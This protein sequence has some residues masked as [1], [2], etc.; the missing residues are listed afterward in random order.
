M[1][2]VDEMVPVSIL[3]LED[4]AFPRVSSGLVILFCHVILLCV[5]DMFGCVGIGEERIHDVRCRYCFM[6]IRGALEGD[7]HEMIGRGR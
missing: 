4:S 2:V 5:V 1:I 3:L 7:G 6:N